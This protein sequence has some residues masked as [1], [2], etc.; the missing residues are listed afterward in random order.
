MDARKTPVMAQHAAAKRAHPDAIVFF[1]L[2]D[3]YEMF[4]DDAVLG[5]RL[6]DLTLTSPNRGN[7][8]EIFL[9]LPPDWEADQAE[10]VRSSCTSDDRDA[11]VAVADGRPVGFVTVAQ[12]D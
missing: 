10:A 5:A 4:G 7:G 1:R 9:R 11:F 12:E 2:G 3:F 6:L 8:D